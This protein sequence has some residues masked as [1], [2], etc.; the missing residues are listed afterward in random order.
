MPGQIISGITERIRRWD[1]RTAIGYKEN[2]EGGNK[3]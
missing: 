1:N 3:H 2:D